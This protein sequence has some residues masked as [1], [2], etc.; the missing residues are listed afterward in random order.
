MNVSVSWYNLQHPVNWRYC[1]QQ[2]FPFLVMLFIIYL[3]PFTILWAPHPCYNRA[4]HSIKIAP[5][6]SELIQ[7]ISICDFYVPFTSI[8]VKNKPD[9]TP[10]DA[11]RGKNFTFNIISR[12]SVRKFLKTFPHSIRINR[13]EY[14]KLQ[15][16]HTPFFLLVFTC[17]PALI[18]AQF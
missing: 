6:Q 16:Y 9:F 14:P 11:K 13:R 18:L 5:F 3:R 2:F 12:D 17:L 15:F 10:S 4:S 1:K 8:L 7:I